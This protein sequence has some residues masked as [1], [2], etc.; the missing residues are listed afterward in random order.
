MLELRR[1]KKKM[2]VPK[3]TNSA[4]GRVSMMFERQSHCLEEDT[5][6]IKKKKG[7]ATKQPMRGRTKNPNPNALIVITDDIIPKSL[8]GQRGQKNNSKHIAK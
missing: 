7:K 5:M 4:T 6:Y 8:N 3:G 1:G 2:I